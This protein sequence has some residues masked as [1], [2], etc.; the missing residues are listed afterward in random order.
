MDIGQAIKELRLKHNMT[1][2]D[3]AERIF[4]SANA[5]STIETGKVYPPKATVVRICKAFGIPTSYLLLASIEREDIP[6]EKRGLYRTLLE[7][8]R[9][10]LLE[11]GT[12]QPT[13]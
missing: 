4:M 1:Q 7:P 11:T 3:L 2:T 12:I 9:N 5:V 8:L 6:E 10:E 13:D